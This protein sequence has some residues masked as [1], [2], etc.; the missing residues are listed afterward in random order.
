[1]ENKRE[2]LEPKEKKPSKA[3]I[4]SVIVLL[5]ALAIGA[6]VYAAIKISH[7]PIGMVI[8]TQHQ[9]AKDTKSKEYKPFRQIDLTDDLVLVLTGYETDGN[10]NLVV[11]YFV[12]HT[13]N[14]W[15]VYDIN[16]HSVELNWALDD[17]NLIHLA[18]SPFKTFAEQIG[19]YTILW[20][21]DYCLAKIKAEDIYDSLGTSPVLL[22]KESLGKKFDGW[23]RWGT[24]DVLN[25]KYKYKSWAIGDKN[26]KNPPVFFVVKDIPEDYSISFGE[27]TITYDDIMERFALKYGQS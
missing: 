19:D 16:Y 6:Y 22:T 14:G 9:I 23:W 24:L 8:R 26:L 13:E 25:P 15:D 5:T 7:G 11:P 1:M 2:L 4:T 27:T 3:I 17:P 10:G 12:L 20:C 18:L 21:G